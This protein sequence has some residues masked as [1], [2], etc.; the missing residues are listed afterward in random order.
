MRRLF[1]LAMGVTIGV[2]I[3]RK[4]SRG[5]RSKLTPGGMADS[6]GAGLR[7]LAESMRDFAADV[8]EAMAEREAELRAGTG[9]DGE[10]G[11]PHSRCDS[12][13]ATPAVNH[14]HA[15]WQTLSEQREI[16][17]DPPA[18]PRPL[19]GAT[20]TPSC[21]ALPLPFDDPNLLFVNAG[22]VQFVPYFVGQQSAA[23][24]A[25]DEHPEVHP[26]A[27][28]RRGRQDHPARHVLPDE[29]QL[30]LR[31]L[32]QG[33]RDPARVG[34]VDEVGRRRRLRPRRRPDL[35]DRLPRRRRGHRHLAQ[36]RSAC[37]WSASSAGAWTTTSGRWA[38]P[39]RAGRAASS[40]TTAA[41]TTASRAARRSTRTATWSSGTSS[42][43]R[44]SAGRTAVRA[45][46][47]ST[48]LG[49]LP[50]KNIDT[51]MGM[52]RMATLLQ[53]VDNL[54]E[55][56]ETRPILDR[57]AELAGKT[58]GA[59]SGH[60]A[61][62]V[63]SRR[64]AAAGHRRPRALGADAHR[65]R[66]RP[67]QRGPRLRAAPHP[68]P[69]DPRDAAARLRGSVRCPSCSRS[70]ATAWRRPTRN[71]R[72]TSSASRPTPT[73]RRTRSGRRCAR[74]RRS[75]TSRSRDAKQAGQRRSCPAT[76]RS[77]CTTPTASRST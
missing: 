23:V 18:L 25:R 8:R 58:Y 45:R 34:P 26:H 65:R 12:T 49:E 62:R 76:R 9:L 27:G 74:A 4:L 24:A 73:P 66:R 13:I 21:R 54:Y 2:L 20:A 33:R 60:A 71:S 61:H 17:R 59:H 38:S 69:R 42:S 35:G 16:C 48:I 46:A 14:A 41:R 43:C 29:R 6:V 50:K 36:R 70:R 22:M 72:R 28:H 10:L 77:S 3:V 63:A 64:R 56:D 37:R 44:T 51:G 52:E 5:G 68:A 39:G 1:W 15:S 55:I 47:T 40:T 75:S 19:R 32:L 11:Q 30:Q 31:R 7:D 67:G 57:A 53:G